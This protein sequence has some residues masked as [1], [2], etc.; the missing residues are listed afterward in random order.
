[1]ASLLRDK[2]DVKI[3]I[4]YLMRNIG[5]PL[6]YHDI[7]AIVRQ[8]GIVDIISFSECFSELLETE[9]VR[10]ERAGDGAFVYAI[11]EQGIHVAD[12]LQSSL[13]DLI[14]T[15][16][17]QSALRTLSFQKRGCRCTTEE[18]VCPDGRILLT[19]TILE[20]E[21]VLMQVTLKVDNREQAD[22]MKRNFYMRPEVIFRGEMAL[23]SGEM[24]YLVT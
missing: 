7:D 8:D 15:T 6:S 18:E 10:E 13:L 21:A 24:N 23:L 4:L 2:T 9:N 22:R 3:F 11:T 20:R 12:N 1:M 14:R 16:S 5:Y 17:L 19:C